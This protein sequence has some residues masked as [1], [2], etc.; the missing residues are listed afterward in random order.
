LLELG[1][2]YHRSQGPLRAEEPLDVHAAQRGRIDPT[3]E[4]LRPDVAHQVRSGVGMPVG[5]TVEAHHAAAGPYRAAIL[6]GIELL[7]REL[8]QEQ[9]EPVELLG[10]EDPV[11]HLV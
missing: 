1:E 8:A 4:L 7:L 3:P 10:V 6:G 9:S 2:V 11:E 5:V